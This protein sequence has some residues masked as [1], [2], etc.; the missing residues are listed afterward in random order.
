MRGVLV[1]GVAA[2]ALAGCNF[3]AGVGGANSTAQIG[4]SANAQVGGD[5]SAQ[6]GLQHFVNSPANAQSPTL[7]EH[8]VDFT[9]DYPQG[10][11]IAPGMGSPQAQNFVKVVLQDANQ[12]DMESFGV[13]TYYGSG[14]AAAD[15]AAYPAFV[16]QLSG[17]LAAGFPNYRLVDQGETRVGFYDAYQ[18]RFTGRYE[19][20]G[21]RPLDI[22]GRVIMLPAPVGQTNG[23]TLLLLATSASDAVH[24]LDDV[25]VRGQ[26]PVLL[27]SFR[28]VAAGTPTSPPP[29]SDQQAGR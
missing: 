11:R 6:S 10:F 12:T 20:A 21:E 1:A 23:V 29:A 24:G 25:G 5:A 26:L 15:R 27:N 16:Q 19:S 18:F 8:Y 14:N 4:G 9:F 28:F 17:Q 13:G 3:S 22:W 2:L 7:R